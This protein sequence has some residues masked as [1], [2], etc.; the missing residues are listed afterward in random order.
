MSLHNLNCKNYFAS[1][2]AVG[3]QL[4]DTL[5]EGSVAAGFSFEM[6]KPFLIIGVRQAPAGGIVPNGSVG[7]ITLGWS[8]P[9]T[10]QTVFPF[11]QLAQSM[12][13]ANISGA[14]QSGFLTYTKNAQG[15]DYSTY[16]QKYLNDE[17]TEI[18]FHTFLFPHS[19][20]KAK[21]NYVDQVITV[22]EPFDRSALNDFAFTLKN[23]TDLR[24]WLPPGIYT[25]AGD[26]TNTDPYWTAFKNVFTAIDGGGDVMYL[27]TAELKSIE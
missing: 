9:T 4:N 3:V 20:I 8:D 17:L 11:E 27:G 19:Q 10:V 2:K 12:M 7:D 1:V 18:N 21:W 22:P 24:M 25:L 5:V 13:S 14:N 26:A 23:S 6:F 16:L 15:A